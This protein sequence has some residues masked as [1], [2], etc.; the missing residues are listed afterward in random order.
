MSERALRAL[1]APTGVSFNAYVRSC[2]LEECR[3]ALI[4][5]PGR[6]VSEMALAWGFGSLSTFYRAF[7]SAFGISPS[8]LR[9]RLLN[10]EFE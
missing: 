5:D 2:R 7:Q 8:E 4:T 10:G 9:A 1:F 3:A 6:Q